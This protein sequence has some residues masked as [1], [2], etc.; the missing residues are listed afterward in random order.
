MIAILL[1]FFISCFFGQDGI[2]S[3]LYSFLSVYVG[4]FILHDDLFSFL[5]Y[6]IL[7]Q[8]HHVNHSP[9]TYFFNIFQRVREK[10]GLDEKTHFY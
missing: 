10:K 7:H 8:Y 1:M 4:H 6:S 5:P 9:F 2:L 3:F